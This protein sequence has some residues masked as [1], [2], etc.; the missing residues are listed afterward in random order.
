LQPAAVA[1][2]TLVPVQPEAYVTAPVVESME[3]PKDRDAASR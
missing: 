3:H 1:V 2:M